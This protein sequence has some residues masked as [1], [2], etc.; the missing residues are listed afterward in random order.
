MNISRLALAAVAIALSGAAHSEDLL[1]I[2]QRALQ[3]DP[4]IRE[5]EANRM[6]SA[7]AAP[8]ARGLLF[9][10]INATANETRQDSN[11]E[12]SFTALKPAT[13]E[14]ITTATPI[15]TPNIVN[16]GWQVELT[17]T[18]FR[19]DQI[20]GLQQAGKR[21]A[22]ADAQYEAAQ[23][24][25]L[26]RVSERYF[27]VLA[28]TDALEASEANRLA[29]AKQLDQSQKRFEVGLI[30]ITDVQESQAAFDQSVADEIAAKRTLATANYLLAEITGSNANDL[31][32]PGGSIPLVSPEP[33]NEQA[34]VEQALAQNLTLV[35]SRIESEIA[36]KEVS[37]RRGGR[38]PT[39]D[40]VVR[41]G[42]NETDLERSNNNSPFTDIFSSSETD[43]ITLQFSVPVFSGFR[44]S[45]RIREAVFL[46]RAARERVQR[47]ARETE[48]L[49]R[50][51]YLGV[52]TEVSRTKALEQAMRSSET[53]LEATQAGFEVG[54]RTTVDVLDAQRN[55]FNARTQ[56]LRARYDYLL[57]V[58]RLK[59][60]SGNLRVQDLETIN[61]LL[62]Q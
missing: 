60:A 41:R 28:A 27:D 19:W 3:S 57:N 9:P 62:I 31:A 25:L 7:E 35:A 39:L 16:T 56:F 4:T 2:Y 12:E 53:A 38:Y 33:A 61:K 30:A 10:Q 5:A 8:Q 34:W 20:A 26:L 1:D 42:N 44:T 58:L 54:T 14:T 36:S 40:L 49:T 43:S 50:D 45:S 59:E 37:V 52:L 29:I 21:V 6:A 22:Q 17:Q 15:E 48:R 18:V 24:N 46:H 11:G 23:Q 51:A 32:K 47:I 55:L 13:R